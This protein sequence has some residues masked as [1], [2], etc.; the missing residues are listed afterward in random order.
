MTVQPQT[1]D[2]SA[3]SR[4]QLVQIVRAARGKEAAAQHVCGPTSDE[5][6]R[7]DLLGLD[8]AKLDAA[9]AEA[10]GNW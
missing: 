2:L 4:M 10:A 7:A 6:I 3:L 9:I 5:Q 1:I 8:K